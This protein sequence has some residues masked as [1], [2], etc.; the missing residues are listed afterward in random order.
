MNTTDIDET[1][2]TISARIAATT[3]PN[4]ITVTYHGTDVMTVLDDLFTVACIRVRFTG[5]Q[6]ELDEEHIE[7]LVDQLTEG[8]DHLEGTAIAWSYRVAA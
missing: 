6:H 7:E 8:L 1:R 2:A 5:H 4:G 3:W